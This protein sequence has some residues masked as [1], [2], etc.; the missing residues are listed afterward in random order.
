MYLS[1][2]NYA[3]ISKALNGSLET[4]KSEQLSSDTVLQELERAKA[5]LHQALSISGLPR[6]N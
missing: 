6:A 4:L 5:E 2:L 1:N 3:M